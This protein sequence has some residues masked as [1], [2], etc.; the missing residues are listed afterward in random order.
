[1]AEPVDFFQIV[2]KEE[3]K[4]EC[5][6]FAKMYMNENLTEFFENS[7]IKKLVME[8]E[9]DKISVCSWKLRQKLRTNVCMPRKLTLEVLKGPFQV[10]SFTCNTRYHQ[11]LAAAKQWHPGILDILSRLMKH[12]GESMPAEVK[13][14][15][16]QNHFCATKEVYQQ[17]VFEYLSPAMILMNSD[18]ELKE[19]CWRDSNYSNLDKKASASA[20][21]L[22]EKIGVPYYPMHTFALE[23]LFAIF[24][25]N[26]KIKVEYL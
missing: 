11:Y 13:N 14:P 12:L 24:C 21:Y 22:K 18:P 23:R 10:L 15:I 17:Y 8:S 16:Y 1:M 25:H 26:K 7:V 19:M 6:P 2:Y 5:F 3:H 4:N 9:S 20:D